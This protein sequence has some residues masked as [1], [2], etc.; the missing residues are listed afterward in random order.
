MKPRIFKTT[1][2]SG[3]IYSIGG[4]LSWWYPTLRELIDDA[5]KRLWL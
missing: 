1:Y 4:F 5:R 3:W 2:D